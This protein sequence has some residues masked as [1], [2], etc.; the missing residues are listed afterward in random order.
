M[1]GDH[2][3]GVHHRITLGLGLIGDLAVDPKRVEPKGGFARGLTGQLQWRAF[4]VD[5]H[6]LVG[7]DVAL[8]HINAVDLKGIAVDRQAHVILD[9][10]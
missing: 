3:F 4:G 1:R 6:H 2:A 7:A 5:H 10:H 8:G 9:P